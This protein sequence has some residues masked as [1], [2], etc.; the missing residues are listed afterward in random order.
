MVETP[1]ELI[2]PVIP[3]DTV[4]FLF[5]DR[6]VPTVAAAETFAVVACRNAIVETPVAFTPL[7]QLST[8]LEFVLKYP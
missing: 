2:L 4:K 8:P 3:P 7:S 6:S 1:T 5:T